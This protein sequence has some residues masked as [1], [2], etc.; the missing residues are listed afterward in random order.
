MH[1][2]INIKNNDHYFSQLMIICLHDDC[3]NIQTNPHL[4]WNMKV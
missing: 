4:M 2:P 3:I 1:G